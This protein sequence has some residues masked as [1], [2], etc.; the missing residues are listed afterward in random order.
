MLRRDFLMQLAGLGSSCAGPVRGMAGL[1]GTA[2]VGRQPPVAASPVDS[3]ASGLREDVRL[4]GIGGAGRNFIKT[5][6][7]GLGWTLIAADRDYAPPIPATLAHER[8][9]LSHVDFGIGREAACTATKHDAVKIYPA[10]EGAAVVIVVASLAGRTGGRFGPATARIDHH[11]GAFTIGIGI[12]PFEFEGHNRNL[13]AQEAL[14][15]LRRNADVT[16]EISNQRQA[17]IGGPEMLLV[18]AFLQGERPVAAFLAGTFA[19]CGRMR[20][21]DIAITT[22]LDPAS[23]RS[24]GRYG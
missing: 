12:T 13:R 15:V 19:R 1:L 24:H 22:P 2:E 8:I 17:E 11:L 14:A 16:I 7:Q 6:C 4:I 10:L 21:I 5:H 3:P 18:D 9:V 20:P 23:G